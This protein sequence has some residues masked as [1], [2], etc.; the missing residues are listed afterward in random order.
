[1]KRI[2][3]SPSLFHFLLLPQVLLLLFA[4]SWYLFRLR[5]FSPLSFF[6][7][8]CFFAAS[9][10]LSFSSPTPSPTFSRLRHFKF[11]SCGVEV[12]RF[13]Q[14]LLR[15]TGEERK[16]KKKRKREKREI[17]NANKAGSFPKIIFLITWAP[18]PSSHLSYAAFRWRCLSFSRSL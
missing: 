14:I 15:P 10:L 1:M 13:N 3:H 8:R 4:L 6:H 9:V 17:I 5:F 16:G 2:S 12:T 18:L 11:A 7:L